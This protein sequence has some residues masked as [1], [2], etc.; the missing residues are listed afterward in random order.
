MQE[1][2][3]SVRSADGWPEGFDPHQ[4]GAVI[5]LPNGRVYQVDKTGAWR[6]RCEMEDKSSE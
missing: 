1:L 3:Q 6:R 2:E 5:R 4:E